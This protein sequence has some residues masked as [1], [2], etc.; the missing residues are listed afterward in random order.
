MK[1]QPNGMQQR[2][3]FI[4]A[5]NKQVRDAI[6]RNQKQWG[7]SLATMFEQHSLALRAAIGGKPLWMKS[8]G[9][10]PVCGCANGYT[11]RLAAAL[12]CGQ[13]PNDAPVDIT[14]VLN[15]SE[16]GAE[17]AKK[18]ADDVRVAGLEVGTLKIENVY[19]NIIVVPKT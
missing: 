7:L 4:G 1:V 14:D 12:H 5:M 15:V 9:A 18:W 13:Y 6:A 8:T 2:M 11:A 17:W 3:M 16:T 10:A 19:Y